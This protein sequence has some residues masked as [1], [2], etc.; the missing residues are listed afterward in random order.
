VP[1]LANQASGSTSEH[2]FEGS[3]PLSAASALGAPATVAD[4]ETDATPDAAASSA[5]AADA[6]SAEAAK[7]VSAAAAAAAAAAADPLEH[8]LANSGQTATQPSS[9]T[10]EA[11]TS[12]RPAAQLLVSSDSV[13]GASVGSMTEGTGVSPAATAEPDATGKDSTETAVGSAA[14]PQV[15]KPVLALTCRLV[16]Q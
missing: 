11:N 6:I 7:D 3:A 13:H 12:M 15:R 10:Q 2:S 4:K 16:L 8:G 1:P 9:V 14:T 5:A